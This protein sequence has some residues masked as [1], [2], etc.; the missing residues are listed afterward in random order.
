MIIS[1]YFNT[2]TKTIIMKNRVLALTFI[3]S[4]FSSYSQSTLIPNVNFEQALINLNIDSDGLNG[5]ILNSDALQVNG[6]LNV[7]SKNITDLTGIEAFKN[8]ESLDCSDNILTTLDL[9]MNDSLLLINAHSNK[10]TS[11]NL[12]GLDQLMSLIIYNNQLSTMD[13]S[14]LSSLGV[15]SC[16]QNKLS[17]LD[18][19]NNAL[20]NHL[21]CGENQLTDTLDISNL[22]DVNF[23]SCWKNQLTHVKTNIQYISTFNCRNNRIKKLDL[24]LLFADYI[25]LDSNELVSLNLVN[26]NNT[27][28]LAF[29]AEGN[30]NLFCI[31][32]DDSGFSSSNVNWLKDSLTIYSNNC[33]A[34]GTDELDH[35]KIKIS[36]NPVQALLTIEVQAP[37]SDYGEIFSVHGKLIEKFEMT[38]STITRNMLNLDP[39]MYFVK[40]GNVKARFMKN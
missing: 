37:S 23:F 2:N 25:Y 5:S 14:D 19:S 13:L 29:H 6:H 7:S 3:L 40:I 39:G 4:I 33:G 17:S 34:L 18:V 35:S 21:S 32:V 28:I 24:S 36:P 10:L 31:S 11:I 27:S 26:G 1:V 15:L 8:L 9:S 16:F 12:S 22:F 30:P 38:N 20:L